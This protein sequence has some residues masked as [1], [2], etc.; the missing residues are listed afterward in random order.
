MMRRFGLDLSLI[1]SLISSPARRL[2]RRLAELRKSVAQ[3]RELAQA[4]LGEL[5]RG[6]PVLR[7]HRARAVAG[8]VANPRF[9]PPVRERDRDERRAQ[10]VH[11]DRDPDLAPLEELGAVDPGELQVLAWP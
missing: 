11:P 8:P 5:P 1:V 3:P 4:E 6:A 10:V 9:G 7:H 2:R